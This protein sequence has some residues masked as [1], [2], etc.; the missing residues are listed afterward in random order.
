MKSTTEEALITCYHCGEACNGS[1]FFEQKAFCCEG[2]K[3][4]FQMLDENNL[5]NYYL[6]N[7]KPG[8]SLKN[9]DQFKRFGYLDDEQAKNKLLSFSDGDVS[10]VQFYI[11]AIH[12]SS[13]IYLL[14]NL[15]KLNEGIKRSTIHF[16]SRMASIT[17]DHEKISLRGV[18]ELLTS[19]GYEPQINLS[20]LE[21]KS[22][23]AH[24]RT[25]YI[26]TGIAFFAFGNIMLLSFPEY[27]GIGLTSE[28]PL[29]LF[30]NYL[31]FLLSLP[32]IFYCAQEFFI[33]AWNA[34]K[35]KTL[36]MDTPIA[37]GLAMMFVRSTYEIFSHTGPGYF[38]T[39]AGL[40]FLM[41]VGRLFQNK[42]FDALSFERNYKS[43]FPVSVSVINQGV[44]N[45]VP[46]SKLRSGARILV[47]NREIIPADAVLLSDAAG[48]DYSFVTGEATPVAK[49][50]GE[51]IY[52]GG[53]NSGK[54]IELETVKEVSQSYLTRL[55]N[56]APFKNDDTRVISSIATKMSKW[57]TPVV[58]IIA[59]ESLIFWW[60]KDLHTALNAF[61]SVLII[62]CPCALAL[63]SPFTL[64]NVMRVLSQ[65]KI[66][67]KNTL[68][69]ERIAKINSIVFDKTGT[70]TNTRGAI[71]NFEGEELNDYELRLVKS[72]VFHS[73]HPLSK[74][75]YH[76]L[77]EGKVIATN[78]FMETEG[79]GIE[80]WVDDNCVRIGS[81]VYLTGNETSSNIQQPGF[82]SAAR[83]YVGINGKVKG[84]FVIR[85]EYR[86]G[87]GRLIQNL[88]TKAMLY[89]VSGDND[90]EK[91]FLTQFV[92]ECNLVFYQ[93]PTDKLKYIEEMQNKG[94]TVMM[95]GDGLNDA[96]ALKQADVGI[97]ISDNTN[98]FSPACDGIIEA[99]G[100]G[101][102]DSLLSYAKRG[103]NI[104]RIS[105][106]IS[107]CYNI[108]GVFLAIRGTMNPLIAAVL[109]PISSVT[110]ITF[111]TLAAN[112][113]APRSLLKN[114][115]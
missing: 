30:F 105:F 44:E 103:M 79:A 23:K 2:C 88:K 16:T 107:L 35:Q 86:Q 98:N 94:Q 9:T 17:F 80:G 91:P 97:A 45:S 61:T 43:Y 90:A 104:I 102:I 113:A 84:H 62:T 11:P 89:V 39:L 110:I 65:N 100:F 71:V 21:N 20:D 109:M 56:D 101:K 114:T 14:E 26:K 58:L 24:L 70:L 67:L 12:C 10:K 46:L 8:L 41:L 115:D 111:T 48:I 112:L 78:D 50:S 85:N 22:P 34:L 29:H 55:W 19:I 33:S 68:V 108:V 63:S 47:R 4:V 99:S 3:A 38:D 32:V 74:K 83:V 37:L 7:N 60:N 53:R 51:L 57:F 82:R 59:F 81:E 87:F 13:C 28:S 95:V 52:A 73:N 49:A 106:F 42:S 72:L 6:L 69:I 75:I 54:S 15:Y 40:V 5:C 96:G 31:S 18:V 92:E 64:G 76:S 1:I 25:Y 93:Q 66:Y 77:S 36:N 27:L